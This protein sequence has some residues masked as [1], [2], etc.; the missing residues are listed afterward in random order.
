[1]KLIACSR[2]HAESVV[3]SSTALAEDEVVAISSIKLIRVRVIFVSIFLII[4]ADVESLRV[5][6]H[7]PWLKLHLFFI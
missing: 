5:D 7:L 1:M 6:I 4:E 2:R 3:V